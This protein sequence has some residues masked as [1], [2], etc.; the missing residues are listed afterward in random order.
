M[1]DRV[2]D[3]CYQIWGL[4][5][6]FSGRDEWIWKIGGGN[7]YCWELEDWVPWGLGFWRGLVE[8]VNV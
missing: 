7:G 8:Y 5:G 4:E 3:K 1:I 6:D 2:G